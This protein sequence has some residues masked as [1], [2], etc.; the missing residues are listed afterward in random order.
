MQSTCLDG[1]TCDNV[2]MKKDSLNKDQE[3]MLW[4]DF[5]QEK[6]IPLLSFADSLVQMRKRRT[7][8]GDGRRARKF[9]TRVR[10]KDKSVNVIIENGSA[11]NLVTQEV[12][13]K[14]NL[15][16]EKLPKP[17]QVTW[18]NGYVIPVTH[19]WYH[20]RLAIIR[21]KFYVLSSI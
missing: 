3:P 11:I 17:Y 19:I 16:T 13:D 10:V 14:L 2:S 6:I 20:S 4:R 21:T 12:I 1:L 8:T 7:E 18:S 15:P 5:L 9:H